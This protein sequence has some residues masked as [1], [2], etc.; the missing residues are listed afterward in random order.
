MP[1]QTIKMTTEMH[2]ANRTRVWAKAEIRKRLR[3]IQSILVEC[4]EL[5]PDAF[6]GISDQ[7]NKLVVDAYDIPLCVD[8]AF[9]Q[10][11]TNK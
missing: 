9:W 8:R 2:A 11:A 10:A 3:Q 5:H 6:G 1:T 4:E 7:A